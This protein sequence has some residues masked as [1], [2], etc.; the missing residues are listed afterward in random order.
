MHW[1]PTYVRFCKHYDAPSLSFFLMDFHGS[2]KSYV[3][4]ILKWDYVLRS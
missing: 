2:E 1:Y 3:L 4:A